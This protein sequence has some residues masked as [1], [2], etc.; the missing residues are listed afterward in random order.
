MCEAYEQTMTVYNA[1]T[2][3]ESKVL[4]MREYDDMIAVIEAASKYLYQGAG[5]EGMR[6]VLLDHAFDK[7]FNNMIARDSSWEP[8]ATDD[9]F[10]YYG[11]YHFLN[12]S[13]ALIMAAAIGDP[14]SL[15]E[16]KMVARTGERPGWTVP[17]G[18]VHKG[19]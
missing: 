7:Y 9:E 1:D 18:N 17:Y 16:K 13:T 5:P 19:E 12:K 15:A 8:N 11:E 14:N 4:S 6:Q 10:A 2:D 3:S